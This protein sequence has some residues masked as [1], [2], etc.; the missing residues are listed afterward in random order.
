MDEIK[1]EAQGIDKEISKNKYRPISKFPPTIRDL[2]FLVP[3]SCDSGQ[4]KNE[5][6]KISDKIL[7]VELFDEF[8]SSKFGKNIKNLAFHI[9]LQEIKGPMEE[10]EVEKIINEIVKNIEQKF[11]AK[12]R[13]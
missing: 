7:L 2:A 9:W 11:Q 5:I 4:V 10:K 12:L 1:I 13:R 6:K 8:E 3:S